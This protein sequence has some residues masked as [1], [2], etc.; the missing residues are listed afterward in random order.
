MV[1]K[2][3][4]IHDFIRLGLTDAKLPLHPQHEVFQSQRSWNHPDITLFCEAYQWRL[5]VPYFFK[6]RRPRRVCELELQP[7]DIKPWEV[8]RTITPPTNPQPRPTMQLPRINLH[9]NRYGGFGEVR[10]VVIHPTQHEYRDI[11]AQWSAENN[12]FALKRL[13]TGNKEEFDKEAEMLKRFGGI[14]PHIICLLATVVCLE[15]GIPHFHLLF[16]WADTDLLRLWKLQPAGIHGV[17]RVSWLAE[18]CYEIVKAVNSIHNP[19][20]RIFIDGVEK[21]GRHGDIKPQNV[22]CFIEPG[23]RKIKFVLSD[24]GL[25]QARGDATRSNIP[26]EGLPGTPNYRP[27][28]CDMAPHQ[29]GNLGY[30]SR[31]YDI[32]TLG[33]LF[34][35]L[36]VWALQGWDG[37]ERFASDR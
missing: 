30:V 25:A 18:Q 34:L 33:C 1:N 7:N 4:R 26:G 9:S 27:P 36:T 5:T 31:S 21:W 32:W 17:Y 20:P 37:A 23:S 16:P 3:A 12:I 13:F 6:E 28:E 35:E 11:L 14:H 8:L 29:G 24:L 2:C 10:K 19:N 22:L 15:N